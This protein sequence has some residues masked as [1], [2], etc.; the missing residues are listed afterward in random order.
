M[1]PSASALSLVKS[2]EGFSS[3]AYKCPAGIWTIGYGT[4]K[5]VKEGDTVDA[6]EAEALLSIDLM[7]AADAICDYVDVP[8]SQNQFDALCSFVY[9]CGRN[10]FKTST[11]LRLLNAGNYVGAAQQFGRWTKGGGKELPGLVR[12]R[13]AER[14]LFEKE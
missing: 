11:L 7:E 3:T 14:E 9:N 12:R 1:T 13:K 8:L 2:F 5:N 4:T 10:A 6:E